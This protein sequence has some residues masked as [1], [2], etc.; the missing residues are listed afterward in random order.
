M[1]D[2]PENQEVHAQ[3]DASQQSE[4]PLDAPQSHT[5]EQH[6][7]DTE[8]IEQKTIDN[9]SLTQEFKNLFNNTTR[10]IGK[11]AGN[12]EVLKI[13]LADMF[14]E[15]FKPH[16][17]QEMDEVF[18]AGTEYTT[19]QLD[20]VSKEW[21][22]PFLF[23]R[24][25]LGL[26]TVFALLWI[27]VAF[28]GNPNGIGGLIFIGALTVPLPVL[29]FFFESNAFKNMS[30]A[31]VFKIF[32]IG[33]VLSLI[34]TLTLYEFV[35]VSD[36]I[37]IFSAILIGIV[38][39]LG[40]AIVTIYFIQRMNTYKIL[41]GLLIGAAV[42]TGFE[43]FESAGYIF[44]FIPEGFDVMTQV[45]WLRAW[46]GIGSHNV[47]TAIVGAAVVITKGS[48]KFNWAHLADKRFLFFFGA[49][50]TLHAVWDMPIAEDGILK[51]ILLITLGWL[52]TFILMKAGLSQVTQLQMEA[53]KMNEAHQTQA[54][55]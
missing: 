41:N 50:V 21:A 53:M 19:P 17:K 29:I 48:Q 5:K 32:F 20:E 55:E 44:R 25:F 4:Q 16:T 38:E 18:I 39:E 13:N 46:T 1:K 45:I 11:L 31:I 28:F 15:V 51:S 47:W 14:S 23:S 33:G 24:I 10:S 43:V 42:G 8:T 34:S 52:L 2:H 22:K 35:P 26:A 6:H 3:K 54:Q 12:D 9:I 27:M 36:D 7:Q 37:T 40:K 30:I 49:A